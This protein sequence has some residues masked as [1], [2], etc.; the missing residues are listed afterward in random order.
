MQSQNFKPRDPKTPLDVD[1]DNI[2]Y[3]ETYDEDLEYYGMEE[4]IT[5][6]NDLEEENWEIIWAD[7]DLLDDLSESVDNDK[8]ILEYINNIK[9]TYL[10]CK[11]TIYIQHDIIR[12]FIDYFKFNNIVNNIYKYYGPDKNIYNIVSDI[13]EHQRLNKRK[14]RYV[15]K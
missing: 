1:I 12:Q 11:T 15:N 4:I 14:K 5:P 8:I 9:L 13:I 2:A 3:D 7:E 6:L 10:S